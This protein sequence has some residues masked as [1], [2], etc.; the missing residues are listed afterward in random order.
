M[1]ALV[2]AL[3]AACA[4]GAAD[5]GAPEVCASAPVVTYESF[6]R[7][8]LTQNCQACHASTVTGEAR[9]GAPE[10]VAFD[11]ADAAWAHADRIL[12]RAAADAP[13]MPPQAGTTDDDRQRLTWWLAC[14]EP[15]T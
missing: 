14:A 13:T 10:D 15:G 8:F 1:I 2:A 5:S 6:G 7:G 11:T 3:L 4:E 9:L 12:A